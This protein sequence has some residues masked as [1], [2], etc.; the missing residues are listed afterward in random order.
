MIKIGIDA[1][2]LEG[3]RTGVGWYLFNLLKQWNRF[4]LPREIKFIL[5]FKKEIP[6]DLNLSVDFFEKKILKAPF[7][8]QSNAFFLHW[9]LMR[10][11]QKDRIDVLFCPA[12]LAPRFYRGRMALTLHDIIY[13]AHPEMYNW[14]SRWDKILLK[15][16]SK[17]SARK[18]KI[19]FTPSRFS[20]KE[21]I[22]Y[23]HLSPEKIIVTPLG[24]D[25]AIKEI[26]DEKKITQIKQ[27]YQIK[28]KFIFYVGSIFNRRHLPE[29][30]RAFER[31]A[32][33]LPQYQFL[34]IGV[35]HTNPFVDI[36]KLVND[37]NR[38]LKRKA[39]LRQEYVSQ[40]D[41]VLLYNAA[42]LLI[43]LSDY[44]GFG[45]P[46]LESIACGTSVVTS[47]C[48]SLPEV[49]GAAALYVKD[50]QSIDEI[51]RELRR[52]LTDDR[53]RKRLINQG[54]KRIEDFSW[55]DCAQKTLDALLL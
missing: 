44:E 37:V 22:K 38:R 43:W 53:L 40:G 27:K 8:L 29:T 7:S 33:D 31:V 51:E 3:R 28:N 47:A 12:Y 15:R 9:S 45:L 17:I 5:Y 50:N 48:A 36:E 19:I 14:P 39:V 11:A 4:A 52:G 20:Q 35:N 18:A 23:Y 32:F 25:E 1:H 34:I 55:K 21:I 49:G 13:E 2:N 46:V 41:L 6:V 16:F 10:A 24:V 26:K 54:R 42:D 30:I